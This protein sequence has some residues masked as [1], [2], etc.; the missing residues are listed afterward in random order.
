MEEVITTFAERQLMRY[1]NQYVNSGVEMQSETC[2][3]FELDENQDATDYRYK[4]TTYE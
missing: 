3:K 4:R 2:L 1:Y